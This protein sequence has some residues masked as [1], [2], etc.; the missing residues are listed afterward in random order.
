MTIE[1]KQSRPQHLCIN[2]HVFAC[3]IVM[4]SKI[5]VFGCNYGEDIMNQIKAG[6]KSKKSRNFEEIAKELGV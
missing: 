5:P 1:D 6:M 3:P 2:C 4:K